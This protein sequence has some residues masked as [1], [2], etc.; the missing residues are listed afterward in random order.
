MKY[1]DNPEERGK[2]VDPQL[3]K[4]KPEDL[5]IICN[6]MSLCLEPEPS[7]R[8]SMQILAAL[9]EDGID[10]TVTAML[11]EYP[12]AWAELAVAS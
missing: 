5:A 4:V 1:L 11:K 2:L 9:L 8:P 12:L 6:V 3:K 7:K 10:V